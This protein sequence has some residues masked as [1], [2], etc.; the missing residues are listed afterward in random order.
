LT[1]I[2]STLFKKVTS[3]ASIGFFLNQAF[4]DKAPQELKDYAYLTSHQPGASLA[5]F[6]F[7]SGK[8]FHEDAVKEVYEKIC[9]PR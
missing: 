2:G 6:S 5:P 7:L 4:S 3:K 8:L 9:Y 1:A